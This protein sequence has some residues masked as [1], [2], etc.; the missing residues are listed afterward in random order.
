MYDTCPG[1]YSTIPRFQQ[2]ESELTDRPSKE[3]CR[4]QSA[5][6][7][8]KTKESS[9]KTRYLAVIIISVNIQSAS[10]ACRPVFLNHSRTQPVGD[11][12]AGIG[13]WQYARKG[14][15]SKYEGKTLATDNAQCS[16]S[17]V[18]GMAYSP[19]AAAAPPLRATTPPALHIY[20]MYT[21]SPIPVLNRILAQHSEMSC[22]DHTEKC[23]HVHYTL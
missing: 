6:D 1:T 3:Q 4:K 22:D 18:T 17:A 8:S 23:V 12:P 16:R 2:Y 19:A 21:C 20:Q 13:V 10:I 5:I 9:L 11:R 15:N 14:C 7:V